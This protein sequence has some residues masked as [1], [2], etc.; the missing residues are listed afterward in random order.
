MKITRKQLRQIIRENLNRILNESDVNDNN[1]EHEVFI[2][3]GQ[4]RFIYP[5]GEEAEWLLN[6]EGYDFIEMYMEDNDQSIEGDLGEGAFTGL[7]SL[8]SVGGA[9][10]MLLDGDYGSEDKIAQYLKNFGA[11]KY[12]RHYDRSDASFVRNLNQL[13]RLE[14][15]NLPSD[16]IKPFVEIGGK[17]YYLD[18]HET[19]TFKDEMGSEI[20]NG[21]EKARINLVG[22][23]TGDGQ[24]YTLKED[25]TI[26][27]AGS[28]NFAT[29][30]IKIIYRNSANQKP[31]GF[32]EIDEKFLNFGEIEDVGID[33][34]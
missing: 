24:Y 19:S 22:I 12:D 9:S 3:P 25:G 5:G 23:Q 15:L 33:E 17:K 30:G 1:E 27:I 8:L 29:P 26:N 18:S 4:I 6:D 11:N 31:G 21:F 14:K 16:Q 7:L 2:E 28:S 34:K 10:E 32:Y 20:N 13:E